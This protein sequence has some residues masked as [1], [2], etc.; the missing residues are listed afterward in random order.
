MDP[1]STDSLD[2]DSMSDTLLLVSLL[3]EAE[4][5]AK[6]LLGNIGSFNDVTIIGRIISVR[7]KW[8][9]YPFCSELLIQIQSIF[10]D[11]GFHRTF[12]MDFRRIRN[13]IDNP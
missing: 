5:R 3:C 9:P 2:I 13:H 12:Q 1:A 8:N 10:I 7:M 11:L 6:E 4:E